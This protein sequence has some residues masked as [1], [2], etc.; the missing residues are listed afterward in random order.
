[1]V[2]T[3]LVERDIQEGRKLVQ[4]L[5]LAGLRINA[6]LWLFIPESSEWRLTIATPLVD[7]KGPLHTYRRVHTALKSISPPLSISIQNIAAISPDDS[8]IQ[9]LKGAVR[10]GRNLEG[11][12]FTRN[13][14]KNSYIEDAYLYRVA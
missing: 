1:M 10:T 6:A 5:D 3:S 12:R 4:S 14:I 8:L 11:V 7:E 13:F 9:Q 2:K